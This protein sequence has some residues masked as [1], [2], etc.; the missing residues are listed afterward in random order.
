MNTD[1]KN[2]EVVLQT[3]K[4]HWRLSIQQRSTGVHPFAILFLVHRLTLVSKTVYSLVFRLNYDAKVGHQVNGSGTVGW[5]LN[6]R[7]LTNGDL[8]RDFMKG[9]VT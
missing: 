2:A 9:S 5:S 1:L 7:Y 3:I 6:L 8:T 4:G